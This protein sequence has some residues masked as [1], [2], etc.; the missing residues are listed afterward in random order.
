MTYRQIVER[1]RAVGIRQP[2]VDA[3]LLANR[4][5]GRETSFL[6]AN[7]D[8]AL[9]D[10]MGELEAAL[11]RRCAREPLQYILGT[12]HFWRQEYLISPACLVPRA[13]TE[14]LLEQAISLLPTGAR[15]LDLCTGSGCIAVSLLCERPDLSAVAVELSPAALDIARQNAAAYHLTDDRLLLVQGDVFAADF[16]PTIGPF[17]AILSNPPYIPTRD[18]ATLPPETQQ[19]PTLALDG[20]EDGL[21]FYRRMLAPDYRQLLYDGGSYLFEIGYDQGDAM[22][23]LAAANHLSCRIVRD[24]GGNDRVAHLSPAAASTST[25]R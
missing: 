24:Y 17:H 22:R 21:Q 9:P 12:W 14:I 16:L 4:F 25:Q 10:P 18:L 7:P 8:A 15:F 3:R 1:L 2:E 20:G 5:S 19:E 6:L 23:A 13:D 11:A